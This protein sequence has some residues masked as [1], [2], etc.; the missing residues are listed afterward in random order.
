MKDA[1]R[2]WLIVFT[3]C[4]FAAAAISWP[5]M[6]R[7]A[8]LLT[9]ARSDSDLYYSIYA[10]WW[11]G[12]VL[13][14]TQSFS[15]N[16]GAYFPNG[17]AMAGSV[18]NF[19]TLFITGWLQL[20]RDPVAAW[21]SA[22]VVIISMNGV[23]GFAL[24][25]RLGGLWG[26]LAAAALLLA[27]P[28]SWCEAF[29]GRH[30]QAFTAPIS[31]AFLALIRL[32]ER[33]SKA[34]VWF[35]LSIALVAATYWF[36]APL[37]V[38]AMLPLLLPMIRDRKVAI[39]LTKALGV[40]CLAVLPAAFIIYPHVSTELLTRSNPPEHQLLMRAGNSLL[41]PFDSL[42]HRNP[43][44][45]ALP[46]FGVIALF[47]SFTRRELRGWG[48]VGLSA[49][50]L[51]MG[52]VIQSGGQPVIVG[53]RLIP[54]PLI[55]LDLLPGFDRFWWPYRALPIAGCA[56]A[57]ALAIIVSKTKRSPLI[58]I[59]IALLLGLESRAVIFQALHA[60]DPSIPT[61]SF[62]PAPDAGYYR[63]ELPAWVK[64]PPS[65]GAVIDH[66]LR[67][68]SNFA[69]LYASY[70]GLPMAIGDGAHEPTI[71]PPSFDESMNGSLLL[72]TWGNSTGIDST[73]VDRSNL[74]NQGYRWFLWHLP[75]PAR[76]PIEH[77]LALSNSAAANNVF[78][79]PV[80]RDRHL[81]VYLITPP[82]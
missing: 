79:E 10:H 7:A 11:A 66:P 3:L 2:S 72:T 69:P 76:F 60:G 20:L 33:E 25:K 57:A 31:L 17:T 16:S 24:G 40:C 58:A 67:Q 35:G 45:R 77:E 64:N 1:I 63:L 80:S 43:M 8:E 68:T 14:G 70:H 4:F 81:L 29:E 65:E 22:T 61:S 6:P 28:M 44:G 26:G 41:L 21:N 50:V 47:W 71:R 23:A 55:A 34:W 30:E 36:M 82:L 53:G 38:V 37:L 73:P 59:G 48:L 74:A 5:L 19:V 52:P 18:W 49:I 39:D 12:E 46:I 62:D 27:L 56:A 32:K 15:H 13:A 51:A 75:D 9:S 54:L 42:S 78:G